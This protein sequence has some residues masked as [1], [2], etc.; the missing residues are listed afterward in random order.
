MKRIITS[1]C[2]IISV[3]VCFGQTKNTIDSLQTVEQNCL[4]SGVRMPYCSFTFMNQMDSILNIVYKK[5][6]GNFNDKEIV[7]LRNEQRK[8]LRARDIYFK[9]QDNNLSKNIK[10]GQW[11]NDMRMITYSTKADYIRTRVLMLIKKINNKEN[12]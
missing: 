8:W 3:S 5:L 11:G 1:I 7:E 12:K 9:K 6:L 10:S 4:D 2:L